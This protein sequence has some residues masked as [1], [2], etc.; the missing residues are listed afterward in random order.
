MGNR[1]RNF[2]APNTYN[3]NPLAFITQPFQ[4]IAYD[5]VVD[6]PVTAQVDDR[7]ADAS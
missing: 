1:I 2:F 6:D 4:S 3:G 7:S 5:P